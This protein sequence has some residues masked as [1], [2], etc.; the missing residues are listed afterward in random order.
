MN[1]T[2]PYT[3]G[4]AI[5]YRLPDTDIEMTVVGKAVSK[6][7]A[8]KRAEMVEKSISGDT[9]CKIDHGVS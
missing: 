2:A 3:I 9:H 7:L 1:T 5:I 4:F 8:R 6:T